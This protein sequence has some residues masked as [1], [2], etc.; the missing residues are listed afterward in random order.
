MSNFCVGLQKLTRL[1]V[2]SDIIGS[3]QFLGGTETGG[4]MLRL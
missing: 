4:R 1:L 3:K 2:Q